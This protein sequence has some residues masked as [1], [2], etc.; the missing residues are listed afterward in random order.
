MALRNRPQEPKT[1]RVWVWRQLI[2]RSGQT[3]AMLHARWGHDRHV[4]LTWRGDPWVLDV[5]LAEL[6][7]DG[8]I[9]CT[10]GQWWLRDPGIRDPR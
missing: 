2:K 8:I 7:R 9:A 6:R 5:A 3:S 10:D 4:L 1:P